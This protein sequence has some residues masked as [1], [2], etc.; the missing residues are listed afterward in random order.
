MSEKSKAPKPKKL[1]P[2]EG[3]KTSSDYLRGDLA[4]ELVDDNAYFGK[5]S[6]QLI[7]HHGSYQQDNRDL[8]KAARAEGIPKGKYFSLMIRTAIPGGKL[9][10]AQLLAELDLCDEVGDATL[11]VTTRQGLQLHGVL[12]Q[13]LKR[14]I[15]KV[16]EI[17]LSTLAACGD[18]RRNVM[19]SPVPYRNSVH[20]ELQRQ[21]NELAHHLRPRTGAYRDLW[22]KDPE[23]GD[24]EKVD[25][26]AIND[27]VTTEPNG[28][29]PDA[30]EPLYGKTYLPRKFKFA[31][32]L[33]GDNSVDLYSQDCGLLAICDGE[34]LLGYNV[35]VG[36]GF[37]TTPSNDNTFPALAKPLAFVTP[38]QVLRIAESV[39]K[40]HRDFGDRENRKRA[41]LKYIVHD[42]GIE[43]FKQVTEEYFGGPLPDPKPV[44]VT[45]HDDGMGWQAQG[46]GKWFYGLN[47]EN[48]RIKNDGTFQLKA[49]LREVCQ[50]FA[51]D[52]FLTPTSRNDFLRH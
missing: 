41:R 8:R 22:L 17:D 5:E 24:K 12:K 34:T 46:D 33:P 31:L 38:G 3:I 2:V 39:V 35:L 11:R 1:S 37:G 9:T 14:V 32:G 18:V 44:T 16:N 51:G 49:A 42:W 47:I 45:G 20:Q 27:F 21:A 50:E 28:K 13:N 10:P 43:K 6:I 48:G 52:I 40:V 7:K 36:G 30:V 23:T 19:C 4:E 29:T 25:I 26:D 15:A